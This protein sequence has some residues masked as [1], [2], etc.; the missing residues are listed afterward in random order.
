MV[1]NDMRCTESVK[2]IHNSLFPKQTAAGVSLR[3]NEYALYS[4]LA[5]AMI[6]AWLALGTSS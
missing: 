4:S 6:L 1:R 3:L 5:S 2:I